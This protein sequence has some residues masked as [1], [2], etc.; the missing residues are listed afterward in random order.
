MNYSEEFVPENEQ[1]FQEEESYPVVFGIAFTPQITGIILGI[2]GVL[3]SLYVL[4]TLVMPAYENYQKLR[5]DE[6]SKQEKVDQHKS[7]KID[8]KLLSKQLELD[9]SRALKAQVLSL[10]SNEKTLETLLLDINGFFRASNVKLLNFK[11]Q[12]EVTVV[13]DDSLGAAVKNKLKRQSINLEIEGTFEQT[14]S[15]LLDIERLQP[16]LLIRN[17]NSQLTEGNFGVSVVR[18]SNNQAKVIPQT[19]KAI[20]TS[21]TLDVILPLSTEDLAKISAAAKEESKDSKAEDKKSK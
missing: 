9:Q 3:G 2:L 21:L 20:K 1:D 13:D 14:R 10:F 19:D 4:F 11:P 18:A 6:R 5:E 16:L 17:F 7:G 15:A 12:G 8:E